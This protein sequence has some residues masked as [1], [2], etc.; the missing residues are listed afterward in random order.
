MADVLAINVN[1]GIICQCLG[2]RFAD[3]SEIGDQSGDKARLLTFTEMA[4]GKGAPI[5]LV[6]VGERLVNR[7]G[8]RFFHLTHRLLVPF[9]QSGRAGP[10][11]CEN[12]F[13]G[14]V[15]AI[16]AE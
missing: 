9:L 6:G 12:S 16:A 14:N 5:F 1:T 11:M 15:Q 8:D 4:R 2:L 10:S 7:R 3:G 13:F